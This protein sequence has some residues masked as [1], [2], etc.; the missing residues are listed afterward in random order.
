[1]TYNP[2]FSDGPLLLVSANKNQPGA[3]M[4]RRKT[5]KSV[6]EPEIC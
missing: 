2:A 3:A 5:Y 4:L 1:M 6:Q